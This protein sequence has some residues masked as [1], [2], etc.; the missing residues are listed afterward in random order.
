[1]DNILHSKLY[2]PGRLV[3]GGGLRGEGSHDTTIYCHIERKILRQVCSGKEGRTH[4]MLLFT[5]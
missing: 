1:M 3:L 2:R 5:V 4:S